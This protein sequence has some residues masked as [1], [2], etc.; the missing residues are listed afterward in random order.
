VLRGNPGQG[1]TSLAV[2]LVDRL[3]TTGV[4]VLHHFVGLKPD[5][6]SVDPMLRRFCDQL[7]DALS[8]ARLTDEAWAREDSKDVFVQLLE[9]AT[10]EPRRRLP[11]RHAGG[12]GAEPRRPLAHLVAVKDYWPCRAARNL[13]RCD[14]GSRRLGIATRDD[15][16]PC[17]LYTN[18]GA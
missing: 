15:R 5:G 8:R 14:R 2:R 16:G 10:A 17:R 11:C 6:A 12:Y 3:E 4:L 7:C 1:K 9:T 18:R 13:P